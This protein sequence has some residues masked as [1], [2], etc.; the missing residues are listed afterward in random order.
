MIQMMWNMWF[1]F[2][3]NR[4]LVQQNLVE[5][6][7][8]LELGKFETPMIIISTHRPSLRATKSRTKT[9]SSKWDGLI[10]LV[11]ISIMHLITMQNFLYAYWPFRFA[12]YFTGIAEFTIKLSAHNI[13]VL[14]QLLGSWKKFQTSAFVS[15]CCVHGSDCNLY[16]LLYRY[17]HAI[18]S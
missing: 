3:W 16:W 13:I 12:S 14:Y 6:W 10:I 17:V 15:W 8:K 18:C 11:V 5:N 7:V 1:W 4:S 2:M 9:I